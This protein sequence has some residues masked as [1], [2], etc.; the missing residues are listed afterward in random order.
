MVIERYNSLK[1]QRKNW[2][3]HWQEIADYFLPRKNNITEKQTKGNK[4]H[5]LIFDGTST[6]A[7]ELLAASLN[8][9]LTN[10]ISPWFHLKYKDADTHDERITR[11]RNCR[12][13][14][15]ASACD[16]ANHSRA[17]TWRCRTRLH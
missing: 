16:S 14:P 9:M 11:K 10:T 6:H 13:Q 3:E 5:D 4:R 15:T 12:Y 2:E 8:G 1:S 7:L 17:W